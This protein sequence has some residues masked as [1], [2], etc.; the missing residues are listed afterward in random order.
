MREMYGSNL[1]W[2]I[3]IAIEASRGFPQYVFENVDRVF[4][5]GH[6]EFLP[7]SFHSIIHQ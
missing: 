4:R 3:I 7:I 1:D 6:D 5:L 2:N